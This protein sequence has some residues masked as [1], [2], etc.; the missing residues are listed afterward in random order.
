MSPNNVSGKGGGGGGG[1][2]EGKEA[3][4][5]GEKKGLGITLLVWGLKKPLTKSGYDSRKK[6][7]LEKK[8]NARLP[9]ARLPG[10]VKGDT[11]W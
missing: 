4:R 11:R 10:G 7:N 8:E 3:N 2:R 1:K 6:E 9:W 5:E